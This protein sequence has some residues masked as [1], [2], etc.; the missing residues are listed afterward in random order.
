MWKSLLL[1]LVAAPVS[2]ALGIAVWAGAN[3]KAG[4]IACC[5]TF[6]AGL[7]LATL[8]AFFTRRFTLFD[9]FLPVIFS[10]LWSL[11]L[12][13]FSLGSDLFTAPA[14]IGSGLLLTLCLWKAYH[15]EGR[16]R[17]WLIF[18]ILV[19]IYEMLPIN[20]PGP[21]DDYFALTGDVVSFILYQLA[22]SHNHQLSGSGQA[23]GRTVAGHAVPGQVIQGHVVQGQVVDRG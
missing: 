15:E 22:T 19:Y 6:A 4:L 2:I 8:M 14:A 7:I 23:Q 18:P 5:C 11:V 1:A 9:V 21:F 10:V 13:P 16:S 3:W 12:M 17:R 20:L